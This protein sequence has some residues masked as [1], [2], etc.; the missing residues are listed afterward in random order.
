M[1]KILVVAEKPSVARDIAAV[2]GCKTKGDGCIS[3]DTHVVSWAIG[4]LVTLFEPEDYDPKLKR[5]NMS[6]LPV[7]P[8]K[9]KIKP[10][11]NTAKQLRIV[12]KL[13]RSKEVDSIVCATDSGREGELIFRYIYEL[14]QCTKPC[15]RLWISSMTEKAIKT[16]FANLKPSSEYDDLYNSARCRSQADWLVGINATRAYTIRYNALL[17]VGRVQT[18]TLAII[19]NR[20]SEIDSFVPVEYYEVTAKFDGYDGKWFDPAV[21]EADLSTRI[22]EKT[23]A[24]EIAAKVPNKPA[25][26]ENVKHETK[27]QPPPLLYDLTELQRDA[28]RR[29]GFSAEKTLNLA[30]DLYEKRKLITYPRTD[31]R[32][33]SEDMTPK[34]PE[35]L[36]KL[37]IPP[38]D[39]FVKRLIGQ[40][41]NITKRIIDDSKVSDHHAI[42]PTE[43]QAS[44]DSLSGDER[45]VFDLIAKRF[46][47][48]FY[49]PYVYSSTAITTLC[50]GERF[51]SKGT[52]VLDLG[53][54]EIYKNDDKD[55]K[56]ADK[57]QVLPDLKKGDASS[58]LSAKAEKKKTKPPSQYNE[59]TLLSAME[60]AGRFI[61]DEAL[62]EQLK[63]SGLGTPATRAGIIERLIKVGYVT[64][65][66]KNLVPTQ[67]A[68][69]LIFIVPDELKSP[70]TTG[71]WEKGLSSIAKG[72]MLPEK[73]MTS[74]S[75]YVR[76]LVGAA[77]KPVAGV[78]FEDERKKYP[79][80][81]KKTDRGTP[82][83][84]QQGEQSP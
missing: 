31:S 36:E 20:Q 58:C 41:L 39:T 74:I 11:Q 33:L 2:I 13:M 27:K 79:S 78:V 54:M 59:A 72:N 64:R 61:D 42:I 10:I 30:Q 19:V 71:K 5:W 83:R 23:Q 60:N 16:G 7:I 6:T 53:Y 3:S 45:K 62:K 40:K 15:S 35:T 34:L 28:N 75:A 48:V 50:E 37:D 46:I 73:F 24:N 57:E 52:T 9:I 29:F 82:S 67:K 32:Y 47:A 43:K 77:S 70:I 65:S 18:P 69:N 80:K 17:S 26:I 55:D 76:F 63:D 8:E 49:P 1:G 38:Y 14:A 56:K 68:K 21:K 84:T 44:L 51:I 81:A 22:A 12:A 25:I 4:H 66:G